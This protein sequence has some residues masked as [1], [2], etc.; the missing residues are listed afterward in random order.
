MITE[1]NIANF[2]ANMKEYVS[3]ARDAVAKCDAVSEMKDEKIN[4]ISK[5]R[6]VG[7]GKGDIDTS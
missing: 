5:E 2:D 7:A 1:S 4:K 3:K 6:L